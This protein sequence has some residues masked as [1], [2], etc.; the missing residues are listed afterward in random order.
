MKPLLKFLKQ[1]YR[2]PVPLMG[3]TP[4]LVELFDELKKGVTSSLVLA[5]FDP[6]KPTFFKLIGARK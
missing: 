5:I 3:W 6:N 1:F 4:A 2:N